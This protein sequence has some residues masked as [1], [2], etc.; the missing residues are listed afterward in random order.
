MNRSRPKIQYA[1][2]Y[3]TQQIIWILAGDGNIRGRTQSPGSKLGELFY[4]SRDETWVIHRLE[5]EP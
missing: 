5:E 3:G 1:T 2:P 4:I